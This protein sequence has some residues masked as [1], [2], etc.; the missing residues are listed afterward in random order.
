MKKWPRIDPGAMIHRVTIQKQTPSS[1][2]SG[3]TVEYTDLY[4]VYAAIEV[5]SASEVIRSGQIVSQ[6]PILVKIY[7]QPEILANMRVVANN[8]TYL[9]QGTQNIDEMNIVLVLFCVALGAND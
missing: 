9:I 7:Y 8:G 3:P 6:V 5:A 4:S 1:D 2:E